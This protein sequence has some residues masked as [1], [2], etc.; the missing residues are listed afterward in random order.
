LRGKSGLRSGR[1]KIKS[2][3][4]SYQGWRS[5]RNS[6]DNSSQN[7]I[8][9]QQ[10]SSKDFIPENSSG[11]NGDKISIQGILTTT[12]VLIHSTDVND[13]EA[14]RDKVTKMGGKW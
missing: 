1:S 11:F 3:N 9:K 8:L 6:L 2:T 5:D 10:G 12:E 7:T 4:N 14:D 13:S